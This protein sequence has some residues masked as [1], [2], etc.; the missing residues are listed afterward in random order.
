MK[1][2]LNLCS[3]LLYCCTSAYGQAVHA[4]ISNDIGQAG[5]Y[6]SHFSNAFSFLSNA[7]C[8]GS[9]G[10]FQCGLTLEQKW[11][12]K[13]LNEYQLAAA[14]EK[15]RMGIGVMF[16]SS[17]D[18][19]YGEREFKLAFGK[20]LGKLELGI[21]FNYLM[22]QVSGYPD[23]GFATSGIAVRFHVTPKLITGWELGLPVFG[24]IGETNTET[25]PGAFRMGMG[26]EVTSNILIAFQIVKQSGLPMNFLGSLEYQYN[27]QFLFSFG[28]DS[29]SGSPYFKSG[30]KKNQLGILIYSSYHPLLGFTPGLIFLWQAKAEKG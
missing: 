14:I 7:A 15:E 1:W 16:R 9:K 11:M 4:S 5:A 21:F 10:G 12:M 27:R 18:T 8:L 24:R 22:E 19:D 25:G 29:G 2:I 6:S 20:N 28:I 13:E 17:G 23:H 26:Y 3:C 30:W